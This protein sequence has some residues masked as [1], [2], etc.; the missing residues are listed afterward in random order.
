MIR[1]FGRAKMFQRYTSSARRVIFYAAHG[2]VL[3]ES[4]EITP[5][6]ILLGLA[7]DRHD[8]DCGFRHLHER[9]E[10]VARAIDLPWSASGRSSIKI[11]RKNSPPLSDD[12]KCVLGYARQEADTGGLFWID[13]DHLQAA[14]FLQGGP[15]AT[16]LEGFGYTLE[17]TRS[18]GSYGRLR[19]PPRRP[20]ISE[21]YGVRFTPLGLFVGILVGLV[22]ANLVSLMRGQ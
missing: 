4:P 5:E 15:P 22:L 7:R 16:A 9:R 18:A 11:G 19:T 6:D 10:D 8:D 13:T 20:T 1:L 3:R 2:A 17:N 12:A 21:R 14:L